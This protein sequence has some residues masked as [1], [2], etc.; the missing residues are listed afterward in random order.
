MLHVINL[1]AGAGIWKGPLYLH[2]TDA[3]EIRSQDSF[4]S[5]SLV[6]NSCIEIAHCWS[7][8]SISSVCYSGHG[9]CRSNV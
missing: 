6:H 7:R 1:L 3:T 5:E 4:E 2:L 8:L 9:G